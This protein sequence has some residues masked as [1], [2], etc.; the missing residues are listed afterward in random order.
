MGSME[1]DDDLLSE[2]ERLLLHVIK[3]QS[4]AIDKLVEVLNM[5]RHRPE[6]PDEIELALAA[7]T[8]EAITA[9]KEARA[10]EA[11]LSSGQP[12]AQRH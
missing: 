12:I 7:K 8:E 10:L 2:R 6:F 4:R 1:D 9:L 11:D 5:T 3:S